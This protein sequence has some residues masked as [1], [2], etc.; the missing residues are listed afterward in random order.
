[1]KTA[2][3]LE[4]DEKCRYQK[5]LKIDENGRNL[6]PQNTKLVKIDETD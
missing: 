4:I 1:M 5:K 3:K 6:N 2:G